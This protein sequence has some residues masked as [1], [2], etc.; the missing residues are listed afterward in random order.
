MRL[1][2][3]LTFLL[4]LPGFG[5]LAQQAGAVNYALARSSVMWAPGPSSL[6]LN[7]AEL[8]RARQSDFG[9]NSAKITG[10]SSFAGSIFLPAIGTF[11]AGVS[12]RDT[13]SRYSFGYSL[14]VG[15]FHSIGVGLS[16]F[17]KTEESIGFSFGTSF[18]FPDDIEN[19]G[20]HFGA[21]VIDLSENTSSAFF[22]VSLGA[23]YWIV[24][25]EV[26]LQAAYRHDAVKNHAL[27]GVEALVL[28]GLSVQ[29]GTRTFEEISGGL[30]FRFSYG[31]VD[32]AAGKAGLILSVRAALSDLAVEQRNT[33]IELG[34]DAASNERYADALGYY[35]KALDY[36]PYSNEAKAAGDTVE[37]LL[38]LRTDKAL[39]EAANL[40]E[41]KE[42]VEASK[43]YSRV[44]RMDPENEVAREHLDNV[45]P[46]MRG[47]IDRLIASG[48]SL[49]NLK[50][51]DRARRNYEDAQELDP[52]NDSI[53]ARIASLEVLARVGIRSQLSRAKGYL[54]R[55]QLDEAEREYERVRESE[56]RNSQ[57]LQGLATVRSKRRDQA[58]QK[59]KELFD[60]GKYF[61]ALTAFVD[62]AKQDERNREAKSYIDRTRQILQ[63]MVENYFRSG[64][65]F[66]TK[67]NYKAA[68]DEWEKGLLIDPNH[69][70]TLE[71]KNR[72]Q[73]KQKA[74]ERLK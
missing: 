72:A 14:P 61:D 51:I 71:Y 63:P 25:D 18:H 36:D 7:P 10:L 40:M 70:G 33:N 2:R 50:E 20:F 42:F 52:E 28:P 16:G 34:D 39:A 26:R 22:S 43:A 59:G 53:P 3:L 54:D 41:K 5:L 8:S 64:L 32:I 13:S 4:F 46:T 15:R 35:E 55:N 19:S 48:D 44:L 49:R 57:A 74:L 62:I 30:S 73:E 38:K 23:A 45:Q 67:E 58:L 66:Y 12:V 60:T 68:L 17:R 24:N 6:F 29:L 27:I 37:A 65:Q 11:G 31:S 9:F 21:S 47:Y 56:P 69:Q 1:L